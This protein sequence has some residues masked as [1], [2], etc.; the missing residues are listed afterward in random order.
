MARIS[1][2]IL[3]DGLANVARIIGDDS[4]D[5]ASYA[6]MGAGE[7]DIA[8]VRTQHDLQGTDV[9]YDNILAVYESP[10]KILWQNTFAYEDFTGG[11]LNEVVICGSESEHAEKSLLRLTFTT[12]TLVGGETVTLAVKAVMQLGS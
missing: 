10:Y 3:N 9:H 4:P 2:T 11:I 1:G 12:I 7:S 6:G 5:P 8:A